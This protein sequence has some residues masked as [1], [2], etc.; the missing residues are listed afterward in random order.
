MPDPRHERRRRTATMHTSAR[1]NLPATATASGSTTA[2]SRALAA[3]LFAV[4]LALAATARG[5][6]GAL[7]QRA[8][9]DGCISQDGSGPC[10]DADHLKG[11]FAVTTSDDGRNAYVA[12]VGGAGIAVLE[13]DKRTGGLTQ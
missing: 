10:R 12:L 9:D 6:A 5:E 11:A 7:T 1:R 8:G 3:T 4:L 13:R 2:A